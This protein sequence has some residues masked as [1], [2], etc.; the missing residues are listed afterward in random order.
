M[1]GSVPETVLKKRKRDEEWAAKKAAAAAAASSKAKA[2]RKVIFKKAETYAKQ[3]LQQASRTATC[4]DSTAVPRGRLG[5]EAG[6]PVRRHN[7]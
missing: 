3:Y 1:A 7:T 5:C 2:Q 6:W 4:G